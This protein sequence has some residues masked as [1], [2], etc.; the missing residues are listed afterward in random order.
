MA[1]EVMGAESSGP[2]VDEWQ[3]RLEQHERQ[4]EHALALLVQQ[5]ATTTRRNWDAYAAVIATLVGLLALVV[6]AF[7]AYVQRQQLRA[8]VWPHLTVATAHGAMSLS[9]LGDP[10]AL[11][12]GLPPVLILSIINGGRRPWSLQPAIGS[13]SCV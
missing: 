9:P 7:T 11:T 2:A 8:Q 13:L 6:S 5:R 12:P 1:A 10:T 3:A 4:L